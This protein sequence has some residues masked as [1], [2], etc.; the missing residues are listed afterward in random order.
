LSKLLGIKTEDMATIGDGQNDVLRF[1]KSGMSIAMGTASNDVKAQA[2]AVTA[3]N[4]QDGFAKA[5]QDL[6][7]KQVKS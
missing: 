4:E 1:K 6:V 3:T 2:T 7:L 5:M